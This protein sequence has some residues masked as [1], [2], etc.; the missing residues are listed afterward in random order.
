MVLVT[1]IV[2]RPTRGGT[3][4][5]VHV[6]EQSKDAMRDVL[7]R[8]LGEARAARGQG[9]FADKDAVVVVGKRT[10]LLGPATDIDWVV[11]ELVEAAAGA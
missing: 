9:L 4:V 5:D 11:E 8:V 10:W 3:L 2:R 1:I 7:R 6:P